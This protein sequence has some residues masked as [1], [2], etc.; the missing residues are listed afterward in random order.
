VIDRDGI[1]RYRGDGVD[2]LEIT[3]LID[4]LITTTIQ[5]EP[6]IPNQFFLEQNFPNPFNPVTLIR[7]SI[8]QRQMVRLDVYNSQGRLIRTL[9]KNTMN[10]G[11][12]E[13]SWD[14]RNST[15][16]AVASGVYYY[17]L[18]GRTVLRTKKMILI[19]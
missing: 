1:I 15:G 2:I 7:F 12:H 9:L 4:N 18:S 11:N 19:R 17:Q 10:A 16:Q 5:A 6:I 8:G 3:S 13:F 14:G